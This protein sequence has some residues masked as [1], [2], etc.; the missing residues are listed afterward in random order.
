MLWNIFLLVVFGY[1]GYRGFDN[2]QQY[3]LVGETGTANKYFFLAVVTGV[4][5]LM[6]LLVLLFGG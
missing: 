4:L 1:L 3:K 5:A 2:Y 6:Q